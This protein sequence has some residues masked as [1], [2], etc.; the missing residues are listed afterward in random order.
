MKVQMEPLF[1]MS[2]DQKG[3]ET[4]MDRGPVR[5]ARFTMSPDQKGIETLSTMCFITGGRSQ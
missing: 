1:T 5:R 2:P 4:A 3:I